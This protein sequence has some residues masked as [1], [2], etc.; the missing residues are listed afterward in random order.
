MLKHQ[1]AQGCA[2]VIAAANVLS[3]SLG[4]VTTCLKLIETLWPMKF[5][6]LEVEFLVYTTIPGISRRHVD[7]CYEI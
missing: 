6:T 5:Q 7:S 2:P 1:I 3:Q 4:V